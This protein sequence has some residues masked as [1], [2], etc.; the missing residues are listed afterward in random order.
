MTSRRGDDERGRMRRRQT[1]PAPGITV[2]FDPDVCIHSAVCLGTL[3]AVFDL[4]RKRWIRP[5]AATAGEVAAAIDRCPSGALRYTRE[6]A[7]PEPA[8]DEPAPSAASIRTSTNGPLLVEGAFMLLDEDGG[9]VPSTG[10]AALCRCG[11]TSNA[12]FCDGTHKVN[13]FR[14]KRDRA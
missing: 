8:G 3:P 5:E 1:Y 14:P 12:P 13:G 11:G 10:R 6:D 2:T 4:G 7:A 9:I